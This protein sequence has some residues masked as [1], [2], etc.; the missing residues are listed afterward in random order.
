MHEATINVANSRPDRFLPHIQPYEFE[1]L[2]FSRLSCLK[3]VEP[4]WKDYIDP[5]RVARESV[6]GPEYIN[7]G[8]GSH[9]SARLGILPGYHKV[10]HGANIADRIGLGTLRNECSHFDR[11]LKHIEDL[12]PLIDEGG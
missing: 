10:L 3:E 11:W 5:L 6:Q 8:P 7:D 1:S 9:P 2:L 12:P 4:G